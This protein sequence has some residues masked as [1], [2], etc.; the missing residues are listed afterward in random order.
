MI[1]GFWGNSIATRAGSQNWPTTSTP[2]LVILGIVVP[3]FFIHSLHPEC[4]QLGS[5]FLAKH[6]IFSIWNWKLDGE[7]GGIKPRKAL[8]GCKAIQ[9]RICFNINW[10]NKNLCFAVTKH[11]RRS[12]VRYIKNINYFR[13][14]LLK[15]FALFRQFSDYMPVLLEL[16]SRENKVVK[17]MYNGAVLIYSS[18]E[19]TLWKLPYAK[20]TTDKKYKKI[21]SEK[22]RFSVCKVPSIILFCFLFGNGQ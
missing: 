10:I 21:I 3:W 7:N 15:Y 14:F 4:Q 9:A 12:Y 8:F 1:C 5:N 20:I 19:G 16:S 6:F 22:N 11:S 2:I 13:H 17:N 18:F